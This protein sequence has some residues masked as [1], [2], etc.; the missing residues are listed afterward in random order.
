MLFHSA[1]CVVTQEDNSVWIRYKEV[2]S[3]YTNRK[4]DIYLLVLR[5]VVGCLKSLPSY[6]LKVIFYKDAGICASIF[7]LFVIR[8]DNRD[9]LRAYLGANGVASGLHYPVPLHLQEAYK[10]LGYK[11]G[12]FPCAEKATTRILSLPMYPELRERDIKYVCKKV[13]EGLK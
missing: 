6:K 3:L 8:T 10:N 5:C 1:R 11:K 4:V 13:A 2:C 9:C 7:H 12:D